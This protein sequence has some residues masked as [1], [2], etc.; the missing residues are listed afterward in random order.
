VL[1]AVHLQETSLPDDM[2]VAHNLE[3]DLWPVVADPARLGHVI[4]SLFAAALES[5]YDGGRI[6]L[7]TRNLQIDEHDDPPDPNVTPGRYVLLSVE[8]RG[9][10]IDEEPPEGHEKRQFGHHFLTRIEILETVQGILE[11]QNGQLLLQ[12]PHEGQAGFR[13]YL[14]AAPPEPA[15]IPRKTRPPA[16][17][18]SG[19]ALLVDDEPVVLHVTCEML[20]RLGFRVL[21]AHDGQEAAAIARL[22][23]GEIDLCVLD[24]G[25]PVMSGQTVFP[26]LKEARP[27]MKVILS[28]GY[29]VERVSKSLQELGADGFIHKPFLMGTLSAKITEIIE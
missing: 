1:R 3:A 23:D 24:L 18:L 4:H 19:T 20:E 27:N 10:G 7:T 9:C 15:W 6:V 14:P 17:P 2:H 16:K 8:F 25:M 13:L 26:L 29:D 21:T 11:T 22:Y 28:S 5:M 12:S